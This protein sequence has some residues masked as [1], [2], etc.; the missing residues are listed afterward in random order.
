MLAGL[1]GLLLKLDQT[2]F[3]STQ[4]KF[5]TLLTNLNTILTGDG[6]ANAGIVKSVQDLNSLLTKL[7]QVTN[8]EELQ[9]LMRE[10]IASAITLRQM[11]GAVQGD[12]ALS[13]EN[14]KQASTQLNDLTRIISQSPSTLIWAEPPAKIILPTNGTPATSAGGAQK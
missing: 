8:N 13:V 12:T 2:D 5:D 14:I 7:N 1:Q 3:S 9:V 11:L 10:I 6:N 4:R